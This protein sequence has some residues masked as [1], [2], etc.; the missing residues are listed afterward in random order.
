MT[1]NQGFE[2]IRPPADRTAT[3]FLVNRNWCRRGDNTKSKERK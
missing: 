3:R 2:P 1:G